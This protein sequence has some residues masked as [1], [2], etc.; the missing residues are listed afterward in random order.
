MQ[1]DGEAQAEGNVTKISAPPTDKE[2]AESL[3]AQCRPQLENLCKLMD[4]AAKRQ[5]VLQWSF[6]QNAY[7]QRFLQELSV[8]KLL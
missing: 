8:V 7:G 1:Q 2:F 4:S 6:G 5:M 3:K